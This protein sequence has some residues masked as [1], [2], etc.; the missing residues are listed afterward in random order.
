MNQFTAL[1]AATPERPGN[2]Q[3]NG[4]RYLKVTHL[5]RHTRTGMKLD[6]GVKDRGHATISDSSSNVHVL[7]DINNLTSPASSLVSPQFK[8]NT[9]PH[10]VFID[11]LESSVGRIS[12]QLV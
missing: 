5:P 10:C 2:Q 7:N 12:W 4:P 1:P 11:Y 6:S 9:L 8:S 3:L